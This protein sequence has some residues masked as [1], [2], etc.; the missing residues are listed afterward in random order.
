MWSD[1][2][3][4]FCG[5]HGI[6]TALLALFV[7]LACIY[8]SAK[9]L[10]A[11]ILQW[12]PNYYNKHFCLF[13][14]FAPLF[15]TCP[16]FSPYQA[17]IH[18]IPLLSTTSKER[19]DWPCLGVCRLKGEQR[20][21]QNEGH[22]FVLLRWKQ[23]NKNRRENGKMRWEKTWNT[24]L[25]PH[26]VSFSLFRFLF[27]LS[28]SLSVPLGLGVSCNLSI[29]FSLAYPVSY[30]SSYLFLPDHFWFNFHVSL[31]MVTSLF[32]RLFTLL[33]RSSLCWVSWAY[34]QSVCSMFVTGQLGRK[35]GRLMA[36]EIL[37]DSGPVQAVPMGS[38]CFL[39]LWNA[40]EHPS[41]VLTPQ[42]SSLQHSSST[43]WERPCV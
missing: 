11:V 22:D 20:N 23:T 42:H 31:P 4:C 43:Y 38:M 41:T 6:F 13:C 35:E 29:G 10:L 39:P 26:P 16:Y 36:T 8:F 37:S 27:F 21:F 15:S 2:L 25:Y 3:R 30:S 18:T 1:A 28:L 5:I 12:L 32:S 14:F 19:L 34:Y 9:C 40:R 17:G 7:W 24:L 33:F